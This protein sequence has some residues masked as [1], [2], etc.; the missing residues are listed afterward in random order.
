MSEQ[1]TCPDCAAAAKR[2][3]H[4]FSANCKG[5]AARAV[6]RGHNYR[7]CLKAGRQDRQY[8]DEL[9]LVGVTHDQVRAAAAADREPQR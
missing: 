6:A 9:A 4:G 7:R 1:E 2:R 8:R 5:C 3:W